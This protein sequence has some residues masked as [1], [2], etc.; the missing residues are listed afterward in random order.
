MRT[1]GGR[2]RSRRACAPSGATTGSTGTGRAARRPE[3]PDRTTPE[4]PCRHGGHCYIPSTAFAPLVG[5]FR[6]AGARPLSAF[7]AVTTM[8]KSA[9]QT[10][11]EQRLASVEPAVEVLLA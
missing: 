2:S 9:I 10:D 4:G 5:R 8:T 6:K 1:H 11:I 3:D 7:D